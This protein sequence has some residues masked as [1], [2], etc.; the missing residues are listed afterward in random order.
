MRIVETELPGVFVVEPDVHHD[1]RG[2]FARTY[3]HD[4][5]R[6]HGLHTDWVQC[7]VSRNTR[8]G[9]LRGMHF[10]WPPHGEIK[11]VRCVK[12]AIFDVAVD[13]RRDSPTFGR[14]FGTTL[15]GD[16]AK[17]LY[18]PVGFAHGFQS[19]TDD[20]EVFYQMSTGYRPDHTGGLRWD[21]PTV[22]IVWPLGQPAVISARD[23][24]LPLLADMGHGL[25]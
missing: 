4:I 1:E 19:L 18:I 20:S 25:A 10:Q 13:I 7:N 21:D 6:A 2:L 9:T 8:R 16:S 22:G 3:S 12:G 15:D 24:A 23:Q 14:W 5:F 11:L 17:A